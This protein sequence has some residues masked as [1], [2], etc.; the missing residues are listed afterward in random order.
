MMTDKRQLQAINYIK[1]LTA[2]IK[3]L[4]HQCNVQVYQEKD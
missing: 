1:F 3:N 4:I 2:E